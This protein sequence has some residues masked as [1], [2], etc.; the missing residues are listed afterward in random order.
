MRSPVKSEH[1]LQA[2]EQA[3]LSLGPSTNPGV[4][5]IILQRAD[6]FAKWLIGETDTQP[7]AGPL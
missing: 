1:R 5:K 4:E 2:L 7:K 6:A 3:V